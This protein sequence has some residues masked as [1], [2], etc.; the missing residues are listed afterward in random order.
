MIPYC[1]FN[2]IGIIPYS[3]IA[4]G[5]LARPVG[6]QTTRTSTKQGDPETWYSEADKAIIGR[7][8]EVAEKLGKSMA[9]V[10]LAWVF[11]KVGNA[12]AGIT[13]IQRLD[14][15]IITNVELSKEDVDY[16]EEL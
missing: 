15:N 3:P 6:T 2:G 4:A 1:K 13:S 8:Q 12:I 16:L 10:A 11:A 7:V 9:Q 5:L 14:Q